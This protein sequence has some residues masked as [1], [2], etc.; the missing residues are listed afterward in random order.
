M[1]A[2]LRLAVD[3]LAIE[4][5]SATEVREGKL[6]GVFRKPYQGCSAG[7]PWGGKIGLLWD[8]MA[9][10]YFAYYDISEYP[11]AWWQP[12]WAFDV[13]DDEDPADHAI[14]LIVRRVNRIRGSG[15]GPGC[16][17][18]VTSWGSRSRP[19]L[20]RASSGRKM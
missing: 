9:K 15:S 12:F 8:G 14:A 6:A 17:L 10:R 18:R 1:S 13:P 3:I 7:H 2:S 16:L 5:V 19:E 11:T 20:V 4:G